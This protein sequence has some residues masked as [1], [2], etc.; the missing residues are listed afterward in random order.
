M[1]REQDKQAREIMKAAIYGR[2]STDRQT[3]S[4][5]TDQ[6]R[7]C[8]GFAK[9]HG[10]TIV[11]T[12]E[13]QGIS[14]AAKGNRPG[15]LRL[16]EDS[17]AL[18]FDVVIVADLSRLSRSTGDLNKM[19]DRLVARGARVV[20]VLDGYDS[21]RR[22]HKLQ[23]GL[24]G[25]MGEAFRDMIKERTHGALES[26]AKARRSAGGKCYGY[27][28]EAVNRDDPMSQRRYVIVKEQASI[29]KEIFQ[30]Y[31]EGATQKSIARN[32][33]E[34]G[35]PSPGSAWKREKRRCRGWMASGIRVIL[36]NVRYTGLV[37]W[38][39]SEWIKDPDS[40]S[41]KRRSRPRSEWLE[42]RDES[43]RIIPDDLFEKAQK[44]SQD[45]SNPD[46]RLKRG[47][48]VK[49]LL[50]GLL[51]CDE[52][53]ANYILTSKTSYQCSGSVGGAC[54]N[55]VRVRRDHVEKAILDPI[56]QELLAPERVEQMAKEIEKQFAKR[57]RE[58]AEKS[59]PEE[60]RALDD[61][62][63]RLQDRLVTGDP[64]L[65]SDELQLAIAAAQRK[66]R[67]YLETQP[68]SRQSAK[69]LSILP[70]AARAYREQIERG[71]DDNP[72]EAAKARVILRELLGPIQ[73]CPG[74]DG[75]LWAQY[76]T[77]PAALIKRAVGASVELNG[78]GGRI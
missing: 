42:Y 58:F 43:L 57:S 64:D 44:R 32:L 69:I 31:A 77:R 41:R 70:K 14:G 67:N 65:E 55:K 37:R 40:G 54:D 27:G 2:Y 18:A 29:V 9:Q 19:I 63:E 35:V 48:K 7:A 76:H 20:G 61:R 45:I 78:S 51:K 39:T 52:C 6:I 17:L 74:K 10:I 60:I 62:I 24:A 38:N 22:G 68:A 56:R 47:G 25:I 66:R 59:T 36:K 8:T 3:E 28:S 50:S 53:G 49:Y 23:A 33:N 11:R 1:A 21:N 30:R 16:M 72:R 71:L 15:V 73:M 12:Y 4:S 5:I 46:G 26:R 13:D 75:S 34:R